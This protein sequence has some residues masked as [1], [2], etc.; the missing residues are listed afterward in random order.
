MDLDV[1]LRTA[2][3]TF[4]PSI[5]AE[6]RL[7][8]I[9]DDYGAFANNRS[10]RVVFRDLI[11][12]GVIRKLHESKNKSHIFFDKLIT[13]FL[14]IYPY[15]EDIVISIV[16]HSKKGI[17]ERKS[18]I[19]DFFP[20]N[21]I[22]IG[23]TSFKSLEEKGYNVKLFNDGAKVVTINGIIYSN[24]M[25]KTDIV[26]AIWKDE[27]GSIPL[28]EKMSSHGLSFSSS[29]KDWIDYFRKLNYRII[30]SAHTYMGSGVLNNEICQ[31]DRIISYDDKLLCELHFG[32]DSTKYS[33]LPITQNNT[34]KYMQFTLKHVIKQNKDDQSKYIT[35]KKGLDIYNYCIDNKDIA[36]FFPLCGITLG[37]T[38]FLYLED[39]GIKTMPYLSLDDVFFGDYDKYGNL[40]NCGV[41]TMASMSRFHAH[42]PVHWENINFTWSM[43][44]IEC[45]TFFP[46][47]GFSI[48]KTKEAM[49]SKENNRSFFDA[50]IEVMSPT[51][52]MMIRLIFYLEQFGNNMVDKYTPNTLWQ[53]EFRVNKS[54]IFN[55]INSSN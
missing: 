45:M 44:M 11:K 12:S 51:K 30:E 40:D 42:I 49:V 25:E 19:N 53:L 9:I 4:G 14:S 26:D 52:S 47:I 33:Q 1:A 28:P 41:V 31:I 48:T 10:F 7:L 8:N 24:C 50:E 55:S 46:N 2:I 54:H 37:V 29:Y 15:K 3:D 36:L 6:E 43:S 13:D 38:S 5:L 22:V 17:I 34:L 27:E 32:Y 23:N 20:M 39:Q 18:S 16:E 35:T 21:G